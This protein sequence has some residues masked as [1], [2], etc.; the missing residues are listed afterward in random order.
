MGDRIR[1]ILT[2]L[3]TKQRQ[4]II[5][6][7]TQQ[8]CDSSLSWVLRNVLQSSLAASIFKSQ[9]A[10]GLKQKHFFTVYKS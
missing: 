2:I 10:Q 4:L 8:M 7:Q 9:Y 5:T 1:E 3:I 6:R